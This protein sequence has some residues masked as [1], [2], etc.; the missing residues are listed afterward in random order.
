[1]I[2]RYAGR[3]GVIDQEN[4]KNGHQRIVEDRDNIKHLEV[5]FNGRWIHDSKCREFTNKECNKIKR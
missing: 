1:M 3:S 4:P 5:F 2:S